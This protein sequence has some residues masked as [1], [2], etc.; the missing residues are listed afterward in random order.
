MLGFAIAFIFGL[1]VAATP[2]G[3]IQ[4]AIQP[5]GYVYSGDCGVATPADIGR[6]CSKESAVHEPVHAYLVGRTFSEYSI[7]VFIQQQ[8]D[9]WI[10][11]GTV[12]YDQSNVIPWPSSKE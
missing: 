10:P 8:G 1:N 4:Q 6:Y 3:A 11:L 5:Y 7:W 2:A 9:E 12:A